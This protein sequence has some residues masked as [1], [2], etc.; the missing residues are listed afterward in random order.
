MSKIPSISSEE[1]T[2]NSI[3][4]PNIEKN[5]HPPS[6]PKIKTSVIKDWNHSSTAHW[7]ICPLAIVSMFVNL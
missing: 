5:N 2:Q 7:S 1:K 4:K 6:N 3:T